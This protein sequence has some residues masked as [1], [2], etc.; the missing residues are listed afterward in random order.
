[1]YN[2]SQKLQ[3]ISEKGTKESIRQGFVSLFNASEKFERQFCNDLCCFSTFEMQQFCDNLTGMRSNS[4]KAAIN[5]ISIYL[6]WCIESGVSGA[7]YNISGVSYDELASFRRRMVSNPTQLQILLDK[8]YRPISDMSADNM[9]RAMYWLAFSGVDIDYIKQMK[10]DN[11]DFDNMVVRFGEKE[12][13]LYTESIP[14]VKSCIELTYFRVFHPL[15]P[16]KYTEQDRIDGDLIFRGTESRPNI[17]FIFDN[18]SRKVK[19]A[20][21][22]GTIQCRFTYET[23]KLSGLFYRLSENER[24]GIK[25]DFYWV[26]ERVSEGKEFKITKDHN[27]RSKMTRIATSYKKDYLNWK[28][29]FG[30]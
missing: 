3:F 10:G 20:N 11:F 25:P 30:I 4:K 8:I 7:E 19:K 24:A 21:K 27:L 2:E 13:R 26:A 23:I 5:R 16:A 22:N 29:A 18:A 9:Y 15:N 1:M 6:K 12:V 28:E 14:A 17:D